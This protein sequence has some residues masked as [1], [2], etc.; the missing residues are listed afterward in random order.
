ML[1]V[2]MATW[3]VSYAQNPALMIQAQQIYNTQWNKLK[4]N[5]IKP[6]LILRPRI[7]GTP[8]AYD[9]TSNLILLDEGFILKNY[10]QNSRE[11]KQVLYY[12]IGH[13]LGHYLQFKAPIA[14]KQRTAQFIPPQNNGNQLLIPEMQADF[15]SALLCYFNNVQLSPEFGQALLQTVSTYYNTPAD[16]AEDHLCVKQRSRALDDALNMLFKSQYL[17]YYASTLLIWAEQ[18]RSRPIEAYTHVYEIFKALSENFNT[19]EFQVNQSLAAFNIALCHARE[20]ISKWSYPL[21]GYLASVS[22]SPVLSGAPRDLGGYNSAAFVEH[23][24]IAHEHAD[25]ALKIDTNNLAALKLKAVIAYLYVD[26][27]DYNK[28][29]NKI[30]QINATQAQHFHNVIGG[31][32]LAKGGHHA[33]AIAKFKQ[34]P[35]LAANINLAIVNGENPPSIPTSNCNYPVSLPEVKAGQTWHIG[36]TQVTYKRQQQDSRRLYSISAPESAGVRFSLNF[37]NDRQLVLNQAELPITRYSNYNPKLLQAHFGVEASL[38]VPTI[39]GKMKV[40][41][42]ENQKHNLAFLIVE[43]KVLLWFYFPK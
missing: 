2:L 10:T 18:Q 33:K 27:A 40:Y 24:Q 20:D 16:C 22:L 6:Q 13:E 4:I 1:L 29:K 42:A 41:S 36:D 25:K 23:I 30:L 28:Y 43:N 19:V 37:S 3:Q 34:T 38:E 12:L 31:I 32:D 15:Y 35:H 17:F 26:K 7:N 11:L 9:H 5:G 21:D 8:S 14:F 39:D